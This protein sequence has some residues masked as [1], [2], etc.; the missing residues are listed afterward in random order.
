MARPGR[1]S[2]SASA[3]S[4]GKGDLLASSCALWSEQYHFSR[5]RSRRAACAPFVAVVFGLFFIVGG[6]WKVLEIIHVWKLCF[7]LYPSRLF[8]NQY[9]QRFFLH[10]KYKNHYRYNLFP[11]QCFCLISISPQVKSMYV[12]VNKE[13]PIHR[14]AWYKVIVLTISLS[15]LPPSNLKSCA[16]DA[17][18][19]AR[20]SR[21]T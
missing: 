18:Q 4:Q 6:I 20:T 15:C 10:N 13:L 12:L 17:H 3:Y 16:I 9:Y 11:Y 21:S 5:R 1:L 2:L 8:S 7:F 19:R 14:K